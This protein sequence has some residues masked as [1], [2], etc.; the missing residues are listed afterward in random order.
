[1][2][3]WKKNHTQNS[4]K[5]YQ[6]SLFVQFRANSER[7]KKGLG[8]SGIISEREKKLKNLRAKKNINFAN[9]MNLF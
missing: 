5:T 8:H 6:N 1:M 2:R 7:L 4:F 9:S 3:S